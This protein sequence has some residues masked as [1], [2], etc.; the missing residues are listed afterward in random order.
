V[1]RIDYYHEHLACAVGF[2]DDSLF[3]LRHRAHEIELANF[4][5]AFN[6]EGMVDWVPG[7][8]PNTLLRRYL[9][10]REHQDLFLFIFRF[11]CVWLRL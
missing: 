9:L 4:A 10:L 8:T 6:A 5:S 7:P 3:A 1:D 11:C 2:A